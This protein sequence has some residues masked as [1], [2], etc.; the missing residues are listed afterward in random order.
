MKKVSYI[1]LFIALSVIGAALKIPFASVG[2]VA[3]DAFP[4][5]FASVLFGGGIGAV[6]AA[7]GHLLSALMAG[8]PLGPFH[9]LIA[10]EMALLVG[11]YGV[12]F[13][14]G[15]KKL[16]AI[17]F[18]LGNT[19]AAPLP[20]LFI[21]GKAFYL[22]IVPALLIGSILNIVVALAVTPKLLA[23]LQPRLRREDVNQ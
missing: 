16:A 21:M 6:I 12:L 7:A 20:F 2:S 10:L 3:L 17:M 13:K 18:V 22:T 5:L 23:I 8:M 9:Y 19:F 4:A 1:A 11:F 15:K 14:E